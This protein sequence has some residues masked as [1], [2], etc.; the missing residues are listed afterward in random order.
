MSVARRGYFI[1]WR[2]TRKKVTRYVCIN[3]SRLDGEKCETIYLVR[4]R[5]SAFYKKSH[6]KESIF[7]GFGV[8]CDQIVRI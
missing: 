8:W 5:S 4:G 6:R 3:K 7:F 1:L 2:F